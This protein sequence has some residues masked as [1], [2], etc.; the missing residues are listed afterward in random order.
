MKVLVTGGNGMVGRCMQDT[1]DDTERPNWIFSG[2]KD[3][4]LRD[5]DSVMKYFSEVKPEYVIHLA[6]N[7]GGLYKNM[8]QNVEMFSDNVRMNENVLEACHRYNVKRGVFIASSCVYPHSPSK[9]PMDESMMHESEPHPS[10]EGYAYAKRMLEL[11]CRN[12]NR[13]YGTQFVC[14]VPVNLYGPYDNF[15]LEDSH[16]VPAVIHKLYL[17]TRDNTDYVMFGTGTPLRQFLYAYDFVKIIKRVL[18]EYDGTDTIICCDDETTIKDMI[19]IIAKHYNYNRE[20]KNDTSRSDGCMRKTVDN[21]RLL[22]IF[23][24]LTFTEL[25]K[26][27]RGTVE[28]FKQNYDMC[29]R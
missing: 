11:Q 9:F 26:G 28:W 12:Y 16:V 22:S 29:R 10:N 27:L 19:M 7:V 21:S 18:L 6:A 1:I 4:D 17:A 8:R 25:D 20:I 2:S 13:Q 3:C 24:D 5:R 14:L 15:N 23:P